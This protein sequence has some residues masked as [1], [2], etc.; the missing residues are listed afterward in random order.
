[1][2]RFGRFFCDTFPSVSRLFCPSAH[3]I[4]SKGDLSVSSESVLILSPSDYWALAVTLNVKTPKEAAS[5]G[6]ALFDLGKEYR[7]E[8]QKVGENSYILIAYSPDELAQRFN[9]LPH[10]S[11][12]KKM[13]FAQ[14]VFAEEPRPIYLPNGK[15]LTTLEG[16]VVEIDPL[17]IDTKTSVTLDEVLSHPRPFL[18]TIP[19]EGLSTAEL[20]PKT[21]T[22]TLVILGILLANLVAETFFSYQNSEHLSQE[23]QSVLELSKLP[24]T[25]MERDAILSNLKAKEVKQL[26]FRQLCKA[27]SDLPIE[28]K[29]LVNP[30]V[31]TIS[32]AVNATPEGIV[33]IPGSKPGEPN[34]LLI[35]H[36]ASAANINVHGEG[37]ETFN[38]DG[39][40][41][42]LIIE[43]HDSASNESLKREIS[44]HFNHAQIND[45][46]TQLEVRLK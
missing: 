3:L 36:T 16:I 43:T 32:A 9:L 39:N 34:R 45:H 7:Y 19:I 46:D 44:K 13:T 8:A 38:Y 37:I 12:I 2:T 18:K 27:I 17:Y 15:Y 30:K 25:S 41:V 10:L 6:A 26:H 28:G 22:I 20:T 11:V 14:W 21:L 24:E 23:M 1:M 5:Y 40:A 4:Y 31:P 33:L 35:E 29:R 42:N